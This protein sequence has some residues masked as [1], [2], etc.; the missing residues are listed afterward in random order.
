MGN[1]QA[2]P[3]GDDDG[4]GAM[5]KRDVAGEAAKSQTEPVERRH[6]QAVGAR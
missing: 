5:R 1:P 3:A 4:V 2:E 6:S